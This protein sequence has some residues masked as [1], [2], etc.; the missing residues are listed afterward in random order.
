MTLQK[1]I[2]ILKAYPD[3]DEIY[4]DPDFADAIQLAIES[5]KAISDIRQKHPTHTIA[6]LPGEGPE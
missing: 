4:S 3:P 5:L 6:L 2:E 1:A